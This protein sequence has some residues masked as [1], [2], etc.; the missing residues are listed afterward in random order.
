LL[1]IHCIW[2]YQCTA[3]TLWFNAFA[4]QLR[5]IFT[6]IVAIL[7]WALAI[8]VCGCFS[9]WPFWSWPFWTS[10]QLITAL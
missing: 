8:L 1:D 4:V 7:V 3:L 9:L 2:I 10:P 5:I 6:N